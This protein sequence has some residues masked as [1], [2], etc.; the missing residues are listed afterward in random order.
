MLKAL[1]EASWNVVSISGLDTVFIL[2]V[3][4]IESIILLGGGTKKRQ[5][6]DIEAAKALWKEYKK[7]K[8]QET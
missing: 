6:K 5:K 2:A 4:V 8:R 7:R 1:A 3:T